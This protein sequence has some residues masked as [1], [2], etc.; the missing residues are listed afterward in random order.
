MWSQDNFIE[1]LNLSLTLWW[2]PRRLNAHNIWADKWTSPL[3]YSR[4]FTCQ[5]HPCN[6]G[7]LSPVFI[8]YVLITSISI[9]TRKSQEALEVSWW[10][11]G[12][13]LERFLS[14]KMKTEWQTISLVKMQT[15]RYYLRCSYNQGLISISIWGGM[16]SINWALL[17]F[18]LEI[19]HY[20]SL[21]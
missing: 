1:L 18:S 5:Q 8:M 4:L 11:L 9:L 17:Q 7:F 12:K 2:L 15:K 19:S 21:L 3:L 16:K 20:D 10:S 6:T 14:W 13:E